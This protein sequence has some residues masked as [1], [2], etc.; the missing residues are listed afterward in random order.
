V[1]IYAS[2]MFIQIGKN[3]LS[4]SDL[5]SEKNPYNLPISTKNETLDNQSGKRLNVQRYVK[6]DFILF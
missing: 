5:S 3:T 4:I 6:I 1:N 2:S